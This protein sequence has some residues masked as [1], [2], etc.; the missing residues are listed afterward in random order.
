MFDTRFLTALSVSAV[1]GQVAA[2]AK[3]IARRVALGTF[4]GILWLIVLAFALAAFTVWLAGEIGTVAALAWIAGG[5]AVVAILI[6]IGLAVTAKR[7]PK[8]K[9][10]AHFE[11]S[12]DGKGAEMDVSAVGSLAIFAAIGFLLGRMVNRRKD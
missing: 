8:A 3:R 5:F 11:A 6:H 2:T 1:K 12:A 4:A 9:L 10:E 7:K